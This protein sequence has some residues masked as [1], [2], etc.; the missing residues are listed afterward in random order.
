MNDAPNFSV[1][2][3]TKLIAFAAQMHT[4]VREQYMAL[5]QLRLQVKQLQKCIKLFEDDFK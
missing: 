1:W 2:P 4:L 5:E 3:T